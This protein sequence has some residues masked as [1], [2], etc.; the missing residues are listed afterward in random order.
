MLAPHVHG[1]L[2]LAALQAGQLNRGQLAMNYIRAILTHP[3]P[4][5]QQQATSV[6]K[7]LAKIYRDSQ[8]LD[9]LETASISTDHL[10]RAHLS[11][12][13]RHMSLYMLH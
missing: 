1:G 10:E 7:G 9:I 8:A 6:R 5:S 12:L 3:V 13:Q 2:S 4:L 11:R